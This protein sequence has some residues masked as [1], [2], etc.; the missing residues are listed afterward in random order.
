M[1]TQFIM[2]KIGHWNFRKLTTYIVLL[3]VT[4]GLVSSWFW[5][6]NMYMTTERR[7][8]SAINTSMA[9]PSAVRTLQEGESGNFVEQK[10]RFFYSPEKVFQNKVSYTERDATT[11]TFV[12][13]EGIVYYPQD[14]FLRYT[15][16]NSRQDTEDAVDIDELI[17][18]WASQDSQES[19]QDSQ[20]FQSELVTLAIFGNFDARFRNEILRDLKSTNTYGDVSVALED[21]DDD[22]NDILTYGLTVKLKPYITALNKAFERAGY[23]DF[24]PLDPSNYEDDSTVPATFTVRKRGNM[25]TKISF[26]GRSEAYSNYGVSI[27]PERPEASLTVEELQQQVREAVQALQ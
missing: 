24:P 9:T 1:N 4:I 23:D 8:W 16:F 10:Y 15:A 14:Q 27:A 22:G 2:N 20:T 18:V 25:I 7:F 12:E 21:V 11:N 26:G 3:A 17:G 6:F 19:E 5:Y 13:T